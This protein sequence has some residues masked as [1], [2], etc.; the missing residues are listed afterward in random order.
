MNIWKHL[1]FAV[2]SLMVLSIAPVGR[3]SAQVVQVSSADPSTTT[4]GTVSLEVTINGSGFDN[5]SLVKF[6]VTGTTDPG[7]ITVRNVVFRNSKRLVATIDVADT[8]AVTKFDIEVTTTSGRK[9]KGTTLFSVQAKVT[10]DACAMPGLDFPAFTYWKDGGKQTQDIYVADSTGACS[11]R[12]VVGVTQA[13]ASAAR[14]SYPVA[15]TSNVGRVVYRDYDGTNH[16]ATIVDIEVNGTS[17]TVGQPY[18][19]SFTNPSA[20]DLSPDG[21]MLY[22]GRYTYE[23]GT[24][25][26]RIYAISIPGQVGGAG[27]L[28]YEDQAGATFHDISVNATHDALFIDRAEPL[29]SHARKLMRLDLATPGAPPVEVFSTNEGQ[30]SPA[31]NDSTASERFAFL[32]SLSDSGVACLQIT[33]GQ[34][35]GAGA[36]FS[37]LQQYTRGHM[38]W[39]QGNLLGNG[40][41][42]PNRRGECPGLGTITQITPTGA[43]VQLVRGWDPDAR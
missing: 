14:F 8:A 42:A 12:I 16:Q 2:L 28:I 17:V 11:R 39:Y 43:A 31:A 3:V 4:Q 33:V 13:G 34:W 19:V 7:G 40:Y 32:N 24:Y 18:L 38:S 23:A 41:G 35:N 15:G 27:T 22:V 29:L 30:L 26:S 6:L 37:P 20:M 10:G 9:G 25:F 36:T 21:T 1:S 5:G